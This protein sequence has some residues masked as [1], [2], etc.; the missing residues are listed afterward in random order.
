MTDFAS[1]RRRLAAA[2]TA[3]VLV[4]GAVG[5]GAAHL[6]A[7]KASVA[8]PAAKPPRKILYWYDP[9]IPNERYDHPGLSS[10]N[11]QTIPKYADDDAGASTT[12][13]GGHVDAGATQALGVR[14][15]TVERGVLTSAVDA[16]GVI[17]FNQRD[18]AIIQARAPGFVT[19]IYARAPGDIVHAGAPIVD[20]LIPSWGG[21]QGEFLAVRRTGDP[22]LIAAAR[23]RLRLLGM[24]DGAIGEV[25]R[26]GRVRGGFTVTTPIGGAIQ[27]LD[28]RQGMAVNAG[29]TLAQVAG[30]STVWLTA[31]TPEA[32]AGQVRVG[33]AARA[34]LAAFPGRTFTGR[35]TAIL[36]TAQADSRTLQVR[37]ELPN[38]DGQLKPGMFATVHLAASATPALVV[39]SEAVIRTGKRDLVM[40]AGTAGH[41]QPVEVRT[42]REAGGRTEILAGLSEGDRVVASGQFLLDS[43]ASLNDLAPR[44]LAAE[45]M[46]ANPR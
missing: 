14:L 45:P 18:L 1:S 44:P 42:G 5:Y 20:L 16:T 27:T 33:Q 4:G 7:P 38:R 12:A 43:E 6:G 8:A 32:L 24:L 35:V 36:P 23:Q 19:R 41:Y 31:A 2:A 40:L 34:E 21:A 3:L 11:M 9:M 30:L 26:T 46:T 37:M 29:Q 39:P 25:E 13:S 10:M 28:A 15:A 17:D 22:A